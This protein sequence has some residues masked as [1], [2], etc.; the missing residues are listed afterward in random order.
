MREHR[1]EL[2]LIRHGQTEWS[3]SGQHTG[4]TDIPLLDEGRRKA[5]ELKRLLEG[6]RFGLVLSSPLSRAYDTCRLAG[7][8]DVAELCDDLLEWDYGEYEGRKTEDIRKEVP[9]WLIWRDGVP[10]GETVD[11]LGERCRRV[12]Q[13]ALQVRDGD[14]ALFGHGHALRALAAVWLEM[15]PENGRL[16]LLSPAAFSVLSYYH[17]RRAVRLWNLTAD[18]RQGTP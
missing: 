15:H 12:I 14:V 3:V 1:P 4:R 16:W 13:R 10:G 7:Y 8:G 17:G 2:Y 18:N 5:G 11:E 6:V 9:G